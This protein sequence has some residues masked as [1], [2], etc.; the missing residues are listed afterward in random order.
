MGARRPSKLQLRLA[1]A[2]FVLFFLAAVVLLHWLSR[3]LHLQFDWTR[4]SQNSLSEASIAVLQRLEHPVSFTAYASERAPL[5]RNVRELIGRYQ[6]HKHDMVLD[7]VDPDREPERARAAGVRFDGEVVVR[8]ETA[9]ETLG[10]LDEENLTNAL[11]R[12]AH[13][14]ERWLVFLGGHGERSPEGQANFDLSL[15]AEQLRKRGFKARVLTLAEHGQVPRNAALVIAGPRVALLPGEL[16]A[17]DAYLDDGGNL[18]WLADPGPLYGLEALAERLGFEIQPGVIVDPASESITGNATA[19][20]T[21]RYSAHPIVRQFR[22]ITLFPG[23]AA[24]R[25][26]PSQEWESTALF[27]TRP[28]AWSE[29]GPLG[30]SVRLDAG[31]DIAGPITMALALTR[32]RG[33]RQQRVVVV[34]DGDFL[35]N[36]FLGN[37]IN[38]ELGTSIVSWLAHDD[39]YVNIP[40]RTQMDRGL[41]L[42]TTARLLIG[43]GFLFVLPL[44]LGGGGLA[45]WWR[46]R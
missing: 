22:N 11:V 30:G 26:L 16:K 1:N 24:L 18:L 8:Y 21:T 3:E 7:F 35:S 13:H 15:W 41:E 32:A 4:G 19:I 6:R 38:L 25:A 29:S 10:R 12:L 37:G 39:A 2:A 45:I 34:G 9:S 46:R 44:A 27:D 33:E 36:R 42:T 14:G 40:V 5:R 23:I 43:G 28:E 17:I 20:V 31:D